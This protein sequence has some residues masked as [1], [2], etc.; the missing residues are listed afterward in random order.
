MAKGEIAHYE[1][2]LILPSA[3]FSNAGL[4][5]G[6]QKSYVCGNGLS[7]CIL[8]FPLEIYIY[9]I[10]VSILVGQHADLNVTLL[11]AS[12]GVQTEHYNTSSNKTTHPASEF[13]TYVFSPLFYCR[14]CTTNFEPLTSFDIA[15]VVCFETSD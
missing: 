15:L 1:Q 10:N 12:T 8:I 14:D 9:I 5:Q 11:N 6:R 7:I 13:W 4:L 2:F 3:M